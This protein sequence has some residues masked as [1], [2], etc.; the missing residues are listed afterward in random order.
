MLALLLPL[1][2][3]HNGR[4]VIMPSSLSLSFVFYLCYQDLSF[5]V[6][7]LLHCSYSLLLCLYRYLTAKYISYLLYHISSIVG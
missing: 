1:A 3:S 5:V 4:S 7:L 2:L 6:F